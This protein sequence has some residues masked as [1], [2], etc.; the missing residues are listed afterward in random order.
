MSGWT[1]PPGEAVPPSAGV[2][3]PPAVGMH[4]EPEAEDPERSPTHRRWAREDAEAAQHVSTSDLRRDADRT[5]DRLNQDVVD[6]R[7]RFGLGHGD[8][9]GSMTAS[10]PFAPV[11]RHP[12]TVVV[13]AAG[14]TTAVLIGMKVVRGRRKDGKDRMKDAAKQRRKEAQRRLADAKGMVASVTSR[15]MPRRGRSGLSRLMHG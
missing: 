15:R 11:R 7:H 5:R 2:S 12:L 9:D 3:P 4:K 1:V 8:A 13:A 6:L 10:G 14:A